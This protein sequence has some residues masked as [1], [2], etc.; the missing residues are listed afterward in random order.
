M[1]GIKNLILQTNSIVLHALICLR[2]AALVI[3]NESSG[4]IP[5]KSKCFPP[6]S[7]WENKR[8][9]VVGERCGN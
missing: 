3:T 5:I 8:R 1:G 4:S 7:T 9:V 2:Y 6:I